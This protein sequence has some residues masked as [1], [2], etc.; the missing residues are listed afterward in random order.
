MQNKTNKKLIFKNCELCFNCINEI[1]NTQIG[2]A[3]GIDVVMPMYNLIEYSDDYSKTSGIS[4]NTV[5][6]YQL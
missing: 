1:N 4:G 6:I 3:K 5:K 2:N